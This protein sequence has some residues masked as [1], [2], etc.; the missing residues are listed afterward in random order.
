[1][2]DLHPDTG[3]I[4]AVTLMTVIC[5]DLGVD[6]DV[7]LRR[8]RMMGAVQAA[9]GYSELAESI[10]KLADALGTAMPE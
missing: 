5:H 8:L 9:E 2:K 4:L 7:V 3:L 10:R 1:M 6:Q